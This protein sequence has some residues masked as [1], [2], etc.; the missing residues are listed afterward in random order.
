MRLY[1]RYVMGN[2][3]WGMFTETELRERLMWNDEAQSENAV[4][5]TAIQ[6]ELQVTGDVLRDQF[7]KIGVLIAL[8]GFIIAIGLDRNS[9]EDRASLWLICAAASFAVWAQSPRLKVIFKFRTREDAGLRTG[10]LKTQWD[11]FWYTYQW[12]IRREHTTNAIEL[13]VI[14]ATALTIVALGYIMITA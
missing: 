11:V 13:L 7:G 14:V 6:G 10:R 4:R 2:A 8:L 3:S 12:L 5:V 1:Q 9:G